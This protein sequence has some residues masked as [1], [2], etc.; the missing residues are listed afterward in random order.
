MRVC[1][2]PFLLL[3]LTTLELDLKFL[4]C[5]KFKVSQSWIKRLTELWLYWF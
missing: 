1:L 4:G 2:A 5:S 3:W